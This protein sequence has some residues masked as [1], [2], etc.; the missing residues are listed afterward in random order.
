MET[1]GTVADASSKRDLIGAN[2]DKAVQL[3]DIEA[4]VE[5]AEV[6]KDTA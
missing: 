6:T 4:K 1:N 3:A 5:K 2:D